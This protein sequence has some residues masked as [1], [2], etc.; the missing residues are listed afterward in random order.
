MKV[1]N[2]IKEKAG[3][4]V[5]E[6]EL[7][8]EG[9]LSERLGERISEWYRNGVARGN[10]EKLARENYF[11]IQRSTL[12]PIPPEKCPVLIQAPTGSGKNQFVLKTL[13][14]IV[15]KQGG[16]VLLLTNRIALT[17]QQRREADKE[18]GFPPY[19]QKVYEQCYISGN[20]DIIDYQEALK[21]LDDPQNNTINIVNT[22]VFDEVHYFLDDAPFNSST[23]AALQ[24]LIKRFFM[25][26]R[27]YM[28]ATPE[29]VEPVIAFEE[30]RAALNICAFNN[31]MIIGNT[32][33]KKIIN[34]D[35]IKRNVPRLPKDA[36]VYYYD[37]AD[38]VAYVKSLG[39]CHPLPDY[40]VLKKY[41]VRGNFDYLNLHFFYDWETI[42]S[43]AKTPKDSNEDKWLI[44]VQEKAQGEEIKESIGKDAVFIN[45]KRDKKEGEV[46]QN[47]VEVKRFDK[48][49]LVSTSVLYNG[50]SIEDASLKHI[51]VDSVDRVQ[52]IQMLGRKRFLN[53]ED[54]TIN[55][56]IKVPTSD[57][58]SKRLKDI[59]KLIG[60]VQRLE[61]EGERFVNEKWDNDYFD[62]RIRGLWGLVAT[63]TGN[64]KCVSEY[65][66]TKL[67]Y[68]GGNYARFLE[69]SKK[70][71]HSMEKA[72]CEWFDV[73][74]SEEMI[75]AESK[76]DVQERI[77][78]EVRE[79]LDRFVAK[80]P[81]NVKECEELCM[82][83]REQWN[84]N[85]DFFSSKS[86]D[87]RHKPGKVG[88][89]GKLV[90]ERLVKDIN[91]VLKALGLPYSVEQTYRENDDQ[92]AWRYICLRLDSIGQTDENPI[93]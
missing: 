66:Y 31:L 35:L 11:V 34:T 30:Y 60:Y 29:E 62:D 20:L 1:F 65:A 37:V 27:I 91:N 72:I 61:N 80:S 42:I 9:W 70:G 49:V 36:N 21:Y 87:V 82:G 33:K 17:L 88:K 19:S 78:K 56:F 71:N 90:Y 40:W 13:L 3:L 25:C 23:S 76:E 2:K 22:V 74:F 26:K 50:V 55:L 93:S 54:K 52:V 7:G 73:E 77:L 28:S 16:R 86:P 8:G 15:E 68:E 12:S 4:R 10:K 46:F 47:I 41:V 64:E 84:N 14:P 63:E 79:L 67:A 89:N 75:F 43:A 69:L 59:E 57:E 32:S 5:D 6:I 18:N 92:S 38:F 48:K 85:K 58:L 39:P 53:D 83:L 24:R 51:V 44:F 81:F 45:A